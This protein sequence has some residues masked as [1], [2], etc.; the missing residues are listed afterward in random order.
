MQALEHL[1]LSEGLRLK[2]YKDS[3]GVWT[4][5]YGRNLQ[6][7]E[8][9]KDV[10]ELWLVQ[11]YAV[12]TANTAMVL[13]NHSISADE[14]GGARFEVLTEMCFNLGPSRFQKFKKMFLHL[15]F[16]AYHEASLEML[17]SLWATQVGERAHRLS[18][19]MQSGTWASLDPPV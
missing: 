16:G 7:L 5:G 14:M 17:D 2:A 18:A 8:I 3:V 10:A 4:I 12:A 15:S 9:T 1:K 19:V 6:E 13:A 11:D